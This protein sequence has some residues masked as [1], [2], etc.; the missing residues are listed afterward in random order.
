[1]NLKDRL[2]KQLGL[3]KQEWVEYTGP[4]GGTGWIN[5][6][7][8]E[9][10]YQEE[11][12]DPSEGSAEDPEEQGPALEEEE[13]TGSVVDEVPDDYT[14]PDLSELDE[15][16]PVL[17]A[18]EGEPPTVFEFEGYSEY[19]HGDDVASVTYDDGTQINVDPEDI[20]T[21]PA[22]SPEPGYNDGW[23][24]AP[25]DGREIPE[26]SVVEVYDAEK[27]E[28]VMAEADFVAENADDGETY[29]DLTVTGTDEWQPDEESSYEEGDSL[30]LG[31][32]SDG[33]PT[34]VE[35]P[36]FTDLDLGDQYEGEGFEA[37]PVEDLPDGQGVILDAS[38]NP[39]ISGDYLEGE[40]DGDHVVFENANGNEKMWK[41]GVH[42]WESVDLYEKPVDYAEPSDVPGLAE[43]DWSKLNGQQVEMDH[44]VFGEVEGEAEVSEDPQGDLW[45]TV[46]QEKE[47]EEGDTFEF[48]GLE[49]EVVDFEE[50]MGDT[51]V[52]LVDDSGDE[53][54]WLLE[55]VVDQMDETEEIS[56]TT[57][58]GHPLNVQEHLG[59]VEDPWQEVDLDNADDV[60]ED[61]KVGDD[62][63]IGDETATVEQVNPG[64]EFDDPEVR[65]EGVGWIDPTEVNQVDLQESI[66]PPSG[67]DWEDPF[68][69]TDAGE[70]EFAQLNPEDTVYYHDSET[71]EMQ[72]GE[73]ELTV[74]ANN[75]DGIPLENGEH[76][77]ADNLEGYADTGHPE[78]PPSETDWA[79]VRTGQH[80]EV[81]WNNH[82]GEQIT[83]SGIVTQEPDSY[84][85]MKLYDEETGEMHNIPT[86]NF[87]D[88]RAVV[89][90]HEKNPDAG[91]GDWQD[92]EPEELA[93]DIM[94]TAG[95]DDAHGDL[96]HSQKD[97]V[98]AAMFSTLPAN[99]V[100]DFYDKM[101]DSNGAWKS[102]SGSRT[103]VTYEKAFQE[104]LDID[105]KTLEQKGVQNGSTP[106]EELIATARVASELSQRHFERQFGSE[107]ELHRG[108]STP[109]AIDTVAN[110]LENPE[111]EEYEPP[112]RSIQNFSPS[113]GTA[114]RFEGYEEGVG[115]G[116]MTV[117]KSVTSDD[118]AA[119]HDQVF[120]KG[121]NE[122]EAEITIH[123]DM[124]DVPADQID[125]HVS[126]YGDEAPSLDKQPHEFDVEEARN[127]ANYL[128]KQGG[129]FEP[130]V[131]NADEE[132]LRNALEMRDAFENKQGISTHS[133]QFFNAVEQ[134]AKLKDMNPD[135][136]QN[137]AAHDTNTE[138]PRGVDEPD[139]LPEGSV[140][141]YTHNGEV[142]DGYIDEVRQDPTGGWEVTIEDDY[143]GFDTV[144]PE[145]VQDIV[146]PMGNA[147]GEGAEHI[148]D[149][150]DPELLDQGDQ[151][152]VNE[153]GSGPVEEGIVFATSDDGKEVKVSIDG[154]TTWLDTDRVGVEGEQD[155]AGA[156]DSGGFEEGAEVQVD[157]DAPE[158]DTYTGEIASVKE[159]WGDDGEDLYTVVDEGGTVIDEL[160]G[161]ELA[162]QA[163]VVGDEGGSNTD[164]L[165][166]GDITT[167]ETDHDPQPIEVEIQ[168][169]EDGHYAVTPVE[170]VDSEY[171]EYAVTEEN[172]VGS[173][174]SDD[175]LTDQ[176]HSEMKDEFDNV[177][178]GDL[179]EHGDE[180][181]VDDIVGE[182]AAE[183]TGVNDNG[184]LMI[185]P[186]TDDLND[187]EQ[188]SVYPQD[189]IEGY[190]DEGDTEGPDEDSEDVGGQEPVSPNEGATEVIEPDQYEFA[191]DVGDSVWVHWP[192]MDEGKEAEV[193]GIGDD[194][195]N[196]QTDDGTVTAHPG[197]DVEVHVPDNTPEPDTFDDF[198]STPVEDADSLQPGDTVI[199][200]SSNGV[201]ER[202]VE[203]VEDGEFGFVQFEDDYETAKPNVEEQYEQVEGSSEPSE[204]VGE[205]LDE[206]EEEIGESLPDMSET[207]IVNG[208]PGA[209]DLTEGT[210][211]EVDGE[212]M[213][214]KDQ[215]VSPF[216]PIHV[217]DGQG[218][219][220]TLD[221]HEI[222]A[223]VEEE[224][225][226]SEPSDSTDPADVYEQSMQEFE[227][228][229]I[230]IPGEG[231]VEATVITT[232]SVDG[233]PY[234]ILDESGD[235]WMLGPN[236][237]E[238][239][240]E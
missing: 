187:G 159:D 196:L 227:K 119:M 112:W 54:E 173:E 81:T 185:D 235:N 2:E 213:Q 40:V 84:N 38:E 17:L 131:N 36:D 176:M 201:K 214:V 170:G 231:V 188:L 124:G 219:D 11:R 184:A 82:N 31:G 143:G 71:G 121:N 189:G 205:L 43:G 172:L 98:K 97:R 100:K 191:F 158:D 3:Q 182:G 114:E 218:N 177:F 93:G 210:L 107:A 67:H 8:G 217:D 157:P 70:V 164:S 15:G 64:G 195:L 198:D 78:L 203:N 128:D 4:S 47:P 24:Q 226:S 199:I 222:D 22:Q 140:V 141:S 104:A 9:V 118:V 220:V 136:V 111:A 147:Y 126:E 150:V 223:T 144:E 56:L 117:S 30:V 221:L 35:D 99:G 68:H 62:V 186:V 122:Q 5:T 50:E 236:G 49:M 1:M 239:V 94:D 146:D 76:V 229:D 151:V 29:A 37:G 179:P 13:P 12:P 113:R 207:D 238:P 61:M 96:S 161:G 168:E 83:A 57:K 200:E 42:G 72:T 233:A 53:Y 63:V 32:D 109:E 58:E 52:S 80:A 228:V 178:D 101:A 133:N 240:E 110:Y 23:Q 132:F 212:V 169:E 46:E 224:E 154:Q 39:S 145:E 89:S 21:S 175:E 152:L 102:E 160:Y 215:P 190:A 165:A 51:Y 45:V 74:D 7:T 139:M 148:D 142:K 20:L 66:D 48:G 75:D 92:S 95:I 90:E 73:V 149:P 197:K 88:E 174:G 181:Y 135:Q 6:R 211:V 108:T 171:D 138:L 41:P 129:E 125:I 77:D 55:D 34:A 153:Y 115:S 127:F 180:I 163:E 105:A 194:A 155:G 167:V 18:E 208:K 183:V 10:R 120:N 69:V 28:Y 202:T 204:D 79:S 209:D 130:I 193:A 134:R 85:D 27:G 230:E 33:I 14:P 19:E 25:E 123:G 26:G 225:G 103:A 87:K 237:L 216:A 206:A 232:P 137:P 16:D 44:P 166:P 65:V 60:V 91:L 156:D 59:G 162:E 116:P 86:S 106:S 234:K 192:G